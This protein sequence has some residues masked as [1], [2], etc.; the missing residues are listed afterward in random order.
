MEGKEQDFAPNKSKNDSTQA[1]GGIPGSNPLTPACTSL[2]RIK[3]CS[4][5]S[6]EQAIQRPKRLQSNGISRVEGRREHNTAAL[7]FAVE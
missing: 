7:S 2:T 3:Q 1:S 5:N 6:D 4:C